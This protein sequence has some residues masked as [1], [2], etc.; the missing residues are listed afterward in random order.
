MRG[1]EMTRPAVIARPAPLAWIGDGY[2]ASTIRRV[3]TSSPA[4]SR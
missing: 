1:M 2:F 4:R 3:N